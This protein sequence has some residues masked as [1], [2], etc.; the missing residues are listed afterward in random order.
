VLILQEQEIRELVD[1]EAARVAMADAFRALHL[2]AA[3]LASVISL[4]FGDPVGVAHI[5]A[6][7]VHSDAVWTA[8][9]SAD[10]YP[11][12]GNATV[13]SG[14]M[15]V[16]SSVD[17]SLAGVLLDNGYLTEI[18]TGAAGALAADML[19][20]SDSTTVAIVG[21]GNQA[22]Y[23]LEA[24]LK[25]RPIEDVRIA[26]RTR[27][28]ADAFAKE[29]AETHGLPARV[30][31]SIRDAV[32]GADI[33]LTTTP[34]TEP[35]LEADW[36]EPGVHITA[37]GSD[38]PTKQEL[39]PAVLARADVVAVDDVGQAARIGELHHA[40]DA[41]VRSE[42][43]VVTLGGLAAGAAVG[44][45]RDEDTTVADLTGVGVQDAAIAALVL[46]RA[47]EAESARLIPPATESA[48]WQH[49]LT[50]PE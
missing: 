43:Q 5:K 2:G 38:E 14:L 26:S 33:V 21:A 7:H 37:V 39:D 23:Q 4:P 44:R 9:V 20:R 48:A 34:S 36:L 46:R 22:R 16:L 27:T 31:N 24:L 8:K 30:Q 32:R 45:S 28:R 12:N 6:G 35:L 11:G 15:L 47:V 17:G 18:R 3:T 40:V 29:V 1:A 50:T 41:G 42:T 13:H 25:V 10:F 49:V 19:S